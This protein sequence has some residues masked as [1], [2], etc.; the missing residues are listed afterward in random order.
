MQ[1]GHRDHFPDC[2]QAGEIPSSKGVSR[3]EAAPNKTP[4]RS[5]DKHTTH[6]ARAPMYT[7][8][9]RAPPC[10][11]L[12]TQ[13]ILYHASLVLPQCWKKSNREG[14]KTQ[15]TK[16]GGGGLD[17]SK[18][19]PKSTVFRARVTLAPMQNILFTGTSVGSPSQIAIDTKKNNN[20]TEMP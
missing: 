20:K 16:R 18:S 4:E 3:K 5:N 6:G 12:P 7:F 8:T 10:P 11:N 15:A 1:I 19:A 2:K 13:K 9:E 17:K 14:R